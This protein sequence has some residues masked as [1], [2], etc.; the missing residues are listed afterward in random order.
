[1]RAWIFAKRTFKEIVRD[2]ITLIFGLGFPGVLI[3]LLTAIQ[4][5]VPV[6]IF[7]IERLAPGMIIFG[8]SFM[9][10][11][12]ATV[13]SKDRESTFLLR[14]YSTPMRATDFIFGYTLPILPIAVLQGAFCYAIGLLLGLDF[15]CGI[16][17]GILFI[18]PIS[19]FFISLG[20]LF[21]SVLNQKQVG[22]ICGALFTNLTA[23]FS[24]I[25]FDLDLV[26][27]VFKSVANALP[28]SHAVELEIAIYSGN[29]TDILVPL[30]VVLGYGIGALL[31]A[32]LFF[33]KQM[34]EN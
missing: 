29:Y 15:R 11:F 8:L 6:N 3:L 20:L 1:M 13:I 27:G 2:P 34:K 14:L 7:E 33:L 19:V 25:W 12:S 16:F 32:V 9:T 28:F 24:G 30:T 21:G 31:L 17:L 26:G 23:W 22:G 10:L 18:I 5:N 4:K